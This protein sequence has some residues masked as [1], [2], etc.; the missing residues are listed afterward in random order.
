MRRSTIFAFGGALA[1]W[2]IAVVGIAVA[3]RVVRR[4]NLN[5]LRGYLAH[6]VAATAANI[7]GDDQLRFTRPEQDTTDE[8]RRASRPLRALLEN[9]PDIHFAY[10]G[11]T[12]GT[13]MHFVMDGTPVDAR[14]VSGALQHAHPMEGDSA[15]PGEIEVTRTR[16]VTVEQEPS[17][18][19]WGSGIRAQAPI[20]DRRGDMAGYVGVTMSADRYYERI[21]RTDAAA[22]LGALVAGMLAC[23]AGLLLSRSQRA[24]EDA[25]LRRAESEKAL[26]AESARSRLFL[27]NASDGVHILNDDAHVVEASDSFCRMLG[28]LR[29][30]VIGLHPSQWDAQ[31]SSSDLTQLMAA[32]SAGEV[33]RFETRHRR[34]DGTTFDVEVQIDTFEVGGRRYR[35]CSARDISELK[36]VQRAL[37]DSTDREQTRLGYDLHEGLGQDLTGI[38]MLASALAAAEKR[39]GGASADELAKLERLARGAISTCRGVAH[40]LSPLTYTEGGLAAALGELVA[41]QQDGFGVPIR[42]AAR[43]EPRQLS[44]EANAQLYRIAQEAIANARRHARANSVD[45]SLD[46]DAG[47]VTLRIEDDGV[48]LPVA[49]SPGMGL[50]IMRFR[51]ALIGAQI[52]IERGKTGGAVVICR[53]DEVL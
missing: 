21:H 49:V 4:S 50:R 3:D 27:R 39:A 22:A 35:Y 48:G 43:G 44:R 18:T 11:V 51:A 37:L 7:D 9:D 6:T 25:D 5:D 23:V 52:S 24:R 41:G 17:A 34:K 38:A 12:T 1:A 31:R 36:S 13:R 40:G 26:A 29:E 30:E 16:R 42:F 46:V 15:T 47:A 28:L 14:S 10:T 53:C 8:Y 2:I 20:F 33:H 32:V 19:A 45:V